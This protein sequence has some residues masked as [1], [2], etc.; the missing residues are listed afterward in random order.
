MI[1]QLHTHT[2]TAHEMK[3]Y[4]KECK[5]Q[6]LWSS[7][8]NSCSLVSFI[9]V[10]TRLLAREDSNPFTN[11]VFFRTSDVSIL[12]RAI[13]ISWEVGTMVRL[14]QWWRWHGMWWGWHNGEDGTMVRMA[15]HVVRM[16]QCWG[17]HVV[18]STIWHFHKY[19]P[20]SSQVCVKA[21]NKL[22]DLQLLHHWCYR[23]HCSV[24]YTQRS[25][26]NR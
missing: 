1:L 19:I 21:H 6:K 25:I 18:I 12:P 2:H 11:C 7:K 26:W 17:W 8:G 15:W 22:G 3:G 20:R 5:V 16:A 4:F 9:N 14:A 24:Y 23:L 10:T 13:G